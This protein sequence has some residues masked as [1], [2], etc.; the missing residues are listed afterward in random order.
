MKPF[1]DL[2]NGS[3]DVARVPRP[4]AQAIVDNENPGRDPSAMGDDGQAFGLMQIWLTTAQGIGFA[5]TGDELLDP[6]TNLAWGLKYLRRVFDQVAKGD[7]SM[8]AAAYN[9]GPGRV[10]RGVII[11]QPYIDRFESH[12]AEW[13]AAMP[14]F[15]S[16]PS[17]LAGAG[18][19]L[20]LLF[21]GVLLPKLLGHKGAR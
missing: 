17:A 18:G 16:A 8:A 21:L 12:L 3:A 19:L 1:E 11:D 5:G 2:V 7:W 10:A 9:E 13:T 4:V 15:Q 6:A 14:D 20:L